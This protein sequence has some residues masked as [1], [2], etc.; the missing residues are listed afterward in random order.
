M[1]VVYTGI[2]SSGKSL[3][4]A[5]KA[6]ELVERNSRWFKKTGIE[7][8]IYSNLIFS[9]DF[10]IYAFSQNVPIYYWNNLEDIIYKTECDVFIDELIKFFDSRQWLNLS[11]DSKHWLT[12]GAKTGIHVY[13]TSQDFSQVEKQFRLLCN[14]VYVVSKLIG[15]PR[16]MKTAPPVKYVWGV[17]SVRQVDSRSFSGDSASMVS[18]S[19]IPSFFFISRED[20]SIFDTNAKVV[21]TNPPVKRLREQQVEYLR[22]GQIIKTGVTYI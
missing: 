7:R 2:E 12:Q 22:D 21:P 8:P 10:E 9:A 6:K 19:V 11:L 5:R 1:K 3:L 4:L 13:A 18:V 20:T 14:E 15:S 16:P 17:I